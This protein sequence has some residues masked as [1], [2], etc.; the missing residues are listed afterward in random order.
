MYITRPVPVV[1]VQVVL[2]DDD[3]D[4]GGGGGGSGAL[5]L[6][7]RGARHSRF[8]VSGRP[9]SRTLSTYVV[10]GATITTTP[11]PHRGDRRDRQL[12]QDGGRWRFFANKP[13]IVLCAYTGCSRSLLRLPSFLSLSVLR[14]IPIKQKVF[15]LLTFIC[16]YNCIEYAVERKARDSWDALYANTPCI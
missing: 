5:L 11:G 2:V 8:R 16:N 9:G 15:F 3:D 14:K 13:C 4:G 7:G 10:A 6:H 1:V 12:R